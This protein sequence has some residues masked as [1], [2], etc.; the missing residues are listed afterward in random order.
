MDNLGKRIFPTKTVMQLCV[1]MPFN[2][3][4]ISLDHGT[5][6]KLVNFINIAEFEKE[7]VGS[8]LTVEFCHHEST[9]A[10][11]AIELWVRL[12]LRI[13]DTADGMA[14][15]YQTAETE[16]ELPIADKEKRKYINRP[17][18]LAHLHTLEEFFELVSLW[19]E[20]LRNEQDGELRKYWQ[21]RYD[22]CQEEEEGL[23]SAPELPDPQEVGPKPPDIG[24]ERSQ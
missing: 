14:M 7:S 4:D 23:L 8:K 12:L 9:V 11:H 13:C 10:P 17:S 3:S 16:G 24:V 18:Q 2:G 19:K 20:V 1:I 21:N 22:L 6:G 5:K 15:N